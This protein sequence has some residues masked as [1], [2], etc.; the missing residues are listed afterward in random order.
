MDLSNSNTEAIQSC[1]HIATAYAKENMNDMLHPAHLLKAILHKDIGL[2]DMLE[3]NNKDYFYLLDWA[4][5]RIKLLKKASKIPTEIPFS[6]EVDAIFHEAEQYQQEYGFPQ[7]DPVFVLAAITTPG[8]G[9]SF[10]QL[11]T[12]PLTPDELLATLSMK[13]TTV[14]SNSADASKKLS[15]NKNLSKF[16]VNK[17]WEIS[18]DAHI[19]V[20]GFE[21]EIQ[22]IFETLGRKGKSNILI[23]GESGVGKTALINA[24][25]KR[26]ISNEVPDFLKEA[27][28]F[29]LDLSLVSSEANYKG[30]IE[31]RVKKVLSEL[32]QVENAIL[33]VEAIEK[34]FDK[35]SILSGISTLLKREISRNSLRLIATTSVEGFTK[36]IETDREFLRLTE[37]MTIEQPD[38]EWAFRIISGVK[39]HYEE[40]YGL[41][42]SE[43][44]IRESIR[45]A[46]RFMGERSLPDSAFDLIDRTLSHVNTMNNIS[47]Q[48]IEALKVKLDNIVNDADK[49]TD[50]EVATLLQWLN[51]EIGNRLS[52]LL[53][54]QL[55]ENESLLQKKNNQEKI[56]YIKSTLETLKKLAQEKRTYIAPTDLSVIVA[57]Q[58]G[59][60]V[61]KLQSKERDKLLNAENIIKQSLPSDKV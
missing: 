10:E 5:A 49:K 58:T 21:K 60:P 44:V 8:V 38:E 27:T 33:L 34:V 19:E 13:K 36:N 50:L 7:L 30:E 46:K 6:A 14:S 43:D 28:V 57:I 40:H 16:T 48:E 37:K 1:L 45:L 41:S 32:S 54:S 23:V 12:F 31:D 4:N 24:F 42:L 51:Q 15:G 29:E 9:F 22:T 52:F 17:N 56:D 20:I 18:N 61:G 55:D 11:K 25:V 26:I 2:V 35:Q 59:V 39:H 3:S 53:I 47:E